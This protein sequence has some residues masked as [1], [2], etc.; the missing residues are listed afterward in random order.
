MCDLKIISG[1]SK[2]KKLLPI[3]VVIRQKAYGCHSVL[4]IDYEA[5]T[6]A[7]RVLNASGLSDI[8]LDGW[9]FREN[10][11]HYVDYARKKWKYRSIG[12]KKT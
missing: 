9:V 5:K 2:I 3:E 7:Y 6:D 1:R 4:I 8:S 11:G 10:F 12:K